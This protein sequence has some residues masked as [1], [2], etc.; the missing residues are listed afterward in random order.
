MRY[1]PD[2]A[3]HIGVG[4]ER[5]P[6]AALRIGTLFFFGYLVG[7]TPVPVANQR[8]GQ[9]AELLR[10]TGAL[11][12]GGFDGHDFQ[13]HTRI[14]SEG[15]VGLRADLHQCFYAPLVQITA[16]FIRTTLFW[17]SSYHVIQAIFF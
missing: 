16:G 3:H 12:I 13:H 2:R 7:R 8:P 17:S 5:E 15:I 6:G 11:A 1:H 9:N 10:L 14:F 4:F